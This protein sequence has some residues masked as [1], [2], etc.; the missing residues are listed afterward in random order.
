MALETRRSTGLD[1][2]RLVLVS[3]SA[4]LLVLSAVALTNGDL[5]A[6]SVAAGF[7]ISLGLLRWRGGFLGRL[8]I[9]LLSGVTLFFMLTAAITNVR[10]GSPMGAVVLSGGLAAV[11]LSGVVSAVVAQATH[12][13]GHEAGRSPLYVA[14]ASL[15]LFVGRSGWS[16][17]SGGPTHQPAD[18]ALVAEKVSFSTSGFSVEAGQVTVSLANQDLFWHTFTIEP[19]GVD[20]PVPVGATRFVTFDV[21]PGTYQFI[22]RIPGHLE[23]GMEG[24][25]IVTG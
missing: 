14:A 23:A 18:A 20:L 7:A 21:K 25:L 3:G 1:W 11:A 13:P 9:G 22:C 15:L 6:G 4:A 2:G 5:E 24:T 12:R 8:G 10:S 16:L 17:T 19:L